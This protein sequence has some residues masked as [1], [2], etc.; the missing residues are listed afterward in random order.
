RK[1]CHGSE[2]W[3]ALPPEHAMSTTIHH[4]KKAIKRSLIIIVSA[5][6]LFYIPNLVFPVRDKIEYSTIITDSK[7]EVIHA[8]LTK[9]EKWRMKTDLDEISPL[10]RQTIVAKEDKYFFYHPGINPLAIGKAAIKNIFRM[11]RTSGASTITMQV[12]KALE[13]KSRTYINKL[14]EIFRAFQLEWKYSKDEI[15]QLYLN[16][17]P[18]GGNIEG[19]KSASILYFKKN[20][21]HLSLAEITA[22][23]IIPNRPSSLII[24]RNNDLIVQERNRW[25]KKF[26]NDK[27]FTS[28]QIEDALQEPLTAS[29]GTVP[30]MIPQLAYK[31]KKQGGDIIR[32]NIETNTQLK[33]EKLVSDYSR[34]LSLK[35]IRNASVVIINNQTHEVMTYVGSANFYDTI[36]GGQVNGP[37]AIR[38]PGSTLKP[39]LFGLCIDEGLITPKAVINDVAVNYDGY[40]PE[41][42]DKQ[43][44]GYVTME[45]ALEHSLNIPAVKALGMLGKDKFIHKL[46]QCDF[47]Q[48]KKDQKKLGLSMILGGCGTSLE[49]LTGLYTIFANEGKFVKPA[50]VD[51]PRSTVDRNETTSDRPRLTEPSG[52]TILSPAATFMINET[53]SKVN[54]PDFP[55]NWQSTERMPKIAWK[56]G[57]SYGRRDAWSIGYN[58]H[59]TVGVWVGNFSGLGIPEI[60]GAN[61]ATPLLFKIF[62]TIDYDSDQEWFEQPKDCD[63][64]IVCSET[65]L[66][67]RDH[68][69]HTVID[70]FIP[71]VSNTQTCNNIQEL[72]ISSE[73]KISFCKTCMP[74]AG[75]K[76]KM[77][78]IISPD[79]QAYFEERNI[80]YEKVPMHNPDCEKIFREGAPAITSPRNGSE[81]LISKKNP[82]ALQLSTNTGNDVTKVYWYINNR[83][84]KASDA[85]TKQFFIPDEGP[86]KISCTDDK[87]RNRDIWIQVRYVNL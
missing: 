23:S 13:P 71:L 54:R 30:K 56:T 27:V 49:E 26:A 14:I 58:K 60:S 37:C 43:F 36:D 69:T 85:K 31:L 5:F 87:G 66:L 57:T 25:L 29:R 8:F 53:L 70:Y 40:A 32:T 63:S 75:Y 79:M 17:V 51:I 19:V 47:T 46:A 62:N 74:D 61:V 22:L 38:Q 39:L 28:K 35:N 10:L 82:E 83:F 80:A 72:M 68:C 9:D 2:P 76:K 67:P 84:Y 65:G 11:K 81:Y 45:Y 34:N 3:H 59:Y 77:Y 52:V 50:I 21:D 86:V 44:N 12:A 18:Y 7:R 24:G 16:I 1:A 55:L 33:V 41:N 15:L 4:I 78:K 48:I 6:I 64:R 42:Y 20:P 73:E